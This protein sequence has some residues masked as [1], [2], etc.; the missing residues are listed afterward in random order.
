MGADIAPEAIEAIGR[1]GRP[2]PHDIEDLAGNGKADLACIDVRGCYI[3]GCSTSV[4]MRQAGALMEGLIEAA[5][6]LVGKL[7]GGQRAD[8]EIAILPLDLGIVGVFF[9]PGVDPWTRRC[10]RIGPALFQRALG[11]ADEDVE[12]HAL[13][14]Q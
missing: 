1:R 14:Q 7:G 8:I 5:G 11:A 2:R 13:L 4:F 6:G 3:D 10:R 9:N 12:Q